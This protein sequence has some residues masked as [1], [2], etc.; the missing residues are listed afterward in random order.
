LDNFLENAKTKAFISHGGYNSLQ[1][2]IHSST[3]IITIP[4][5]GD[6]FR[7]GRIAEKHGFGYYLPKTQITEENIVKALKTVLN[8]ER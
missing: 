5:F 7:N 6:Q 3:P 8:D 4:L 2:A 1:E